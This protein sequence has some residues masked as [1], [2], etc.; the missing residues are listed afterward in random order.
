MDEL[1]TKN[2]VKSVIKLGLLVYKLDSLW[3]SSSTLCTSIPTSVD[4]EQQSTAL[5]TKMRV[6]KGVTCK[7]LHRL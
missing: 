1:K 2:G 4:R 5:I 3:P 7:A 6:E